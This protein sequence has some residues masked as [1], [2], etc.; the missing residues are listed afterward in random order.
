MEMA[1]NGSKI[2]DWECRV[3]IFI[4]WAKVKMLIFF[5][6]CCL[7]GWRLLALC[8]YLRFQSSAEFWA[9]LIPRDEPGTIMICRAFTCVPLPW[10]LPWFFSFT[11][12]LH[13][14]SLPVQRFVH[15]CTLRKNERAT[16]CSVNEGRWEEQIS[17]PSLMQIHPLTI[18]MVPLHG[19]S[20]WMVF[21]ASLILIMFWTI[22]SL[23]KLS[24]CNVTKSYL[25]NWVIKSVNCI[26][27]VQKATL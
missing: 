23:E 21:D 3:N 19:F 17:W 9:T 25:C 24:L 18:L 16:N 20:K 11:N 13:P 15:I 14:L 12:H 6:K 1:E 2:S 10:Q 27:K 26:H 5:H 7:I 8:Y 22:I 4:S